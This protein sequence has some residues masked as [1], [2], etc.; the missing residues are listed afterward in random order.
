MTVTLTQAILDCDTQFIQACNT[1]S[2]EQLKARLEALAEEH[3]ETES[4]NKKY[5]IKLQLN[6]LR[7]IY[8][9]KYGMDI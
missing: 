3:L 5:T 8:R 9:L 2:A 1:D 6:V 7:A 4:H